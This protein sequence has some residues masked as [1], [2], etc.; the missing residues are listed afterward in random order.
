MTMQWEGGILGTKST[1]IELYKIKING[2]TNTILQSNSTTIMNQAEKWDKVSCWLFLH[3]EV[4][5]L[6]SETEYS[7][8]ISV[9][10]QNFFF[11]S[12]NEI[13][14]FI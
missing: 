12:L 7:F 11:G 3:N 10:S 13:R 2:K 8:Y 1:L 4:K 9:I 6:I 14:L 5:Y